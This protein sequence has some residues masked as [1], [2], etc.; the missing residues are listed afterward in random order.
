MNTVK[1]SDTQEG[2]FVGCPHCLVYS[3]KLSKDEYAVIKSGQQMT[4]VCQV[5][6]QVV[7]I[8]A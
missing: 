6:G 4:E 3:I 8:D 5:C 1:V 7:T 2:I